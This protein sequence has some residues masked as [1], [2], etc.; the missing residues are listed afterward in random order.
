MNE[1]LLYGLIGGA[2][3]DLLRIINNRYQLSLPAYLKSIN[4]YVG[5]IFLL[6]L[7]M[8][9][10][11]LLEAN[12]ITEALSYGYSAPQVISGLLGNMSKTQK[13]GKKNRSM[14]ESPRMPEKFTTLD[15][16]KW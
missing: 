7:G 14:L 4:F 5:F 2:I 16:W 13:I 11:Q 9:T 10:V 12:S 3:P 6:V 15:F 1:F 8:V